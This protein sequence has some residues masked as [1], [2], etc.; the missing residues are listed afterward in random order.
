MTKKSEISAFSMPMGLVTDYS[1]KA[2]E[3]FQGSSAQIVDFVN[4]RLQKNMS[5]PQKLAGCKDPLEVMEA[6]AD[7][8]NTAFRDYSEQTSKM[9]KFMERAADDS[10]SVAK[11]LTEA[12][13]AVLEQNKPDA[14]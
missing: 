6:W 4:K 8:Y 14:A 10:K 12:G 5:L 2:L 11:D 9:L 3:G 13:K 7:Y 1:T